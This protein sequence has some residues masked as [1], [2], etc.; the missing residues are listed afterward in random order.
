MATVYKYASEWKL[1]TNG[2][3]E[4]GKGIAAMGLSV[5]CSARVVNFTAHRYDS[6]TRKLID[7]RLRMTLT[8]IKFG[9]EK[10]FDLL[11]SLTG[12][13][14]AL[15]NKEKSYTPIGINV[16]NRTEL[17]TTEF[18]GACALVSYDFMK[19]S[20]VR[21]IKKAAGTTILYLGMGTTIMDQDPNWLQK[22]VDN[23]DQS[24]LGGNYA[25]F[26]AANLPWN[27]A[28]AASPIDLNDTSISAKVE[29]SAALFSGQIMVTGI[30]RR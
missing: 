25:K 14:V 22:V 7:L 11:E 19:A 15:F 12:A 9:I 20:A 28:R 27:N 6:A 3:A 2:G 26:N 18:Q 5:G 24:T 17:M 1:Q 10:S 29:C 21:E 30:D 4:L 13:Q 16:K 23:A 8:G